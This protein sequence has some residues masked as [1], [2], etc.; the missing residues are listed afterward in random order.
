MRKCQMCGYLVLGDGEICKHCG[1]L[2]PRV[3][4]LVAAGGPPPPAP[5][6]TPPRPAA[7]DMAPA[8]DAP[9]PA[10]ASFSA[11]PPMGLDSWD[12]PSPVP[13]K[14]S[15]SNTPRALIAFIAVASLVLGW[16]GMGQFFSNDKLPAGTKAFVSGHGIPFSSPDHTFD[17]QFP[18]P[19]T[20]MQRQFSVSSA[21]VTL[22]LAQ[23][24]T[25]DYEVVAASMVVPVSMPDSEVDAAIDQILDA[26]AAAQDAHIVTRKKVT[27]E[28]ASGIEVRA[29]IKDGY[30][31]RLLVVVSGSHFYLLG[32]HAKVG[33]GR[34]YDALV[35]SL[36]IY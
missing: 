22:N 2:L 21:T 35:S 11:P 18:S 36:I 13:V 15:R 26:G 1:A 9:L 16:T 30:D 10:P 23:A 28:G 33:T 6:A 29:K 7:R 8:P 12:P 4:A 31:A 25:D 17:A 24:Q 3:S 32:V 14:T 34:L 20:L 27:I 19:P 5:A